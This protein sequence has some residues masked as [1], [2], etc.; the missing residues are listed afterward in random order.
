MWGG[1]GGWECGGRDCCVGGD[2]RGLSLAQVLPIVYA[3]LY[4]TVTSILQLYN[5]VQK[6]RCSSDLN[7]HSL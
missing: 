3:K 7:T 6:F 1:G 5:L 2:Y 4:N